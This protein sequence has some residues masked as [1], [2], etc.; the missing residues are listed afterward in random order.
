[1]RSALSKY[2][3]LLF[4]L[5]K[6]FIDPGLQITHFFLHD[7]QLPDSIRNVLIVYVS[8]L[9]LIVNKIYKKS[10]ITTML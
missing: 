9:L 2:V 10:K 5:I 1:M 7:L 4:V 3:I 8:A 6:I